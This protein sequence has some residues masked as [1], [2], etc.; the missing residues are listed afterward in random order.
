MAEKSHKLLSVTPFEECKSLG[1]FAVM[2]SNSLIMLGKVI[3]I[4]KYAQQ[5]KLVKKQQ[6]EKYRGY[7]SSYY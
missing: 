6:Q 7:R 2:D 3:H 4:E 5:T 1:R